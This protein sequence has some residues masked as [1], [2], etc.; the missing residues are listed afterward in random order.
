MKNYELKICIYHFFLLLLHVFMRK[1]VSILL[2]VLLFASCANRGIG[3]QGG[4]KDTIPPVPLKSDPEMGAVNFHGDRIEVTFDEYIQLDNIGSN[5]MMSPPQV[6]PPEVKARSKRLMIQFQDSLRDSTTYTLDFGD[7]VCDFREKTPLHGYSFYFATGPEI[8]TLETRGRVYDAETLNP[9]SGVLVGIHKDFSDSAI[10]KD[11]FLRIAKTD[12]QGYFRIG[13]IHQGRYML[14]AIDD[15]SRDYRL[16]IGE[17]FAFADEP[18]QIPSDEVPSD[19]VPS[20]KDSIAMDSIAMDSIAADSIPADSIAADSIVA[21]ITNHQLPLNSLFLFRQKQQKLYLQRTLRDRQHLITL[22][23][24]SSPDSLPEIHPLH[25]SLAH[26]IH[27]STHGDTVQIWLTDSSSIRLDSLYFDA[28]Y[29]RTDSLNR[30]EWYHDTVQA[31]WR[32]PKLTAK[33]KE[34]EERKNRNRRLEIKTNA[35]KDFEVFDT[36]RLTTSTPLATVYLDSIRL[37]E[38]VDT[39]RQPV[40]F[41]LAPHDTMPMSLTLLA[42]FKPGGQY[43]LHLDSA[44]MFDIYGVTHVA[45]DYSLK[46]KQLEDYSTLRVKLVPF[47]PQARIQLLNGKDAVLRELPATEEGAFFEHLK[48]DSYYLRLY[49]DLNGDGEWTTGS[50]ED[51]RQPEP[52]YYFPEKIQTKSNWDFEQE[53]DMHAKPQTESKPAELIKVKGEK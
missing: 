47:E 52:V 5:L 26:I 10:I 48:P 44:A 4:P 16:T 42:E 32:A 20:T 17:A 51:K 13:N 34:A 31:I 14:Y 19:E 38:R 41:T 8:D 29:R 23:F 6:T 7:A 9:V 22:L 50:W 53:W 45:V 49:L 27:C 40:P 12:A 46:V 36:L 33:A 37:F 43:E 18:I 25:D 2:L 39:V 21:L 11:P 24:S 28:R 3:P 1:I 15:I 35:R 30:L